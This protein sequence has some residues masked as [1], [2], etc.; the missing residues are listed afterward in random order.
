MG[1]L[2]PPDRGEE[3]VVWI[4]PSYGA[5]AGFVAMLPAIVN[6]VGDAASGDPRH[7]VT[8]RVKALR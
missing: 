5:F 1:F 2:S 4:V 7:G 6:R 8:W 3:D